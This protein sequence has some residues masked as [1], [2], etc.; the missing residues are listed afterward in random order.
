MKIETSSENQRHR[1]NVVEELAT[2]R[3]IPRNVLC[4]IIVLYRIDK[5][6]KTR[7]N[8]YRTHR[9][10]DIE[11]SRHRR[12]IDSDPTSHWAMGDEEQAK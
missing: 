1:F 5:E 6:R 12:R 9:T 4:Q 8:G 2:S 3:K 7:D 11:E 10:L